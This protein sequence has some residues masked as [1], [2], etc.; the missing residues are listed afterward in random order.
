MK[1][2]HILL[3][4]IFIMGW[5]QVAIGQKKQND[6]QMDL[7]VA[8]LMSKMTLEEKI[9]QLNLLSPFSR[10]GPF[11]N[12][13]LEEKMKDGNAG[14][15]YAILGLP[16]SVHNKLQYVD[17]T[18]MHI[19]F[20]SGLDIIHGFRTV[21]PIPL[22]LSCTWDIEL[23][24]QTA[25][26]A[27]IEATAAGYNW[28]FSPMVDLTRDPRWGR[29]MEGS[30]EDPYLGSQIASAVVRGYQGDDLA[31]N[32]SL[33]SCVK[34][35]ALYGA[36][37][38]GRDYNTVEMNTLTMYEYYLPPYKAAIDAGAGSIMTS[39]NDINGVPSTGNKWLLTDLLRND[40]GF[41]GF[42]VTD[43]NAIQEMINHGVATDYEQAAEQSLNAGVDMDM[44]SES[45]IAS[46]KNLLDEGK[47]SMK[48]ID[49]ACRR[50][51]EVKYKMGLFDDPY[52]NFNADSI[53]SVTLT[54]S[55]LE[56]AKKAAL[57]SF[58]LLENKNETL[59]L[60]KG[61]KIAL[62]G[63]F[64]DDQREMF[65]SWTLAGKSQKVVSILDGI[66]KLNPEVVYAL[67][68]QV[69][70]DSLF[71]EK[72]RVRYDEAKQNELV[73]DAV[74]VAESADVIITVLGES[75]LMS[76]EA[77]SRT[78]ISIPKCQV[79]LLKKL[80]AT[81]KPVVLVLIT[82]R[83]LILSEV[84]PYVD[85]MVVGWRPGTE[86]GSAIAEVLFGEYNPSG[87]LTMTFPRSV[88]QI[89]IYYNHKNTGRPYEPG[90]TEQFV[91][92]YI[93][94]HN[95]P[96]YPFGYGLSYTQYEYSN[97]RISKPEISPTESVTVTMDVKNAGSIE[98]EEIVQLYVRDLV[99][100]VTQ[101][102]M[103]LKDFKRVMLKSGQS[104]SVSFTV[105]PEKL[106]FFNSELKEV[107]E[108]GDFHIMIGP[109][110]STFDTIKLTVKE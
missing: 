77:K 8:N 72:R 95:T 53:D 5:M 100:S 90:K 76:G 52:R 86:A 12:I 74:S 104:E 3:S 21:F 27:A 79:E 14:N 66:K 1:K 33:L 75:S 54:S 88:G 97:L 4:I 98:G 65:S 94:A 106:K 101:P 35:F 45:Y 46:L 99:S 28:T 23:I 6:K 96:L 63:P 41:D 84:I 102:I 60:K 25:R 42:V 73:N 109:S 16:E 38:A 2:H 22:G 92:N 61:N 82:G 81:G 44:A 39:F 69:I 18:R 32:T 9:G 83:P 103:K 93:D 11:A 68:S 67:G 87:K 85:A 51:L 107:L 49:L 50:V 59:P 58:V 48:Q 26:I 55:H 70:D 47:V 37:E 24:E 78:N 15:L 80:K 57:E 110:S 71:L 30:G 105:T 7:F 13:K 17:S 40:W 108:P 64:A 31:D 29:V 10:T 34:H 43:F 91:S 20:L 36:A 89:P 62:I 56:I 19:P